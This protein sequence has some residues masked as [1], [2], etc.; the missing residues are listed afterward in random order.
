MSRSASVPL[1][2]LLAANEKQ[3]DRLSGTWH[4]HARFLLPLGAAATSEGRLIDPNALNPAYLRQ[5]VAE[6]P[7]AA[8]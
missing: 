7:P 8:P 5:K 4:P 1:S 6:K 2:E 3:F